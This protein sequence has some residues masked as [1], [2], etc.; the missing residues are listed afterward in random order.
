MKLKHYYTIGKY[1]GYFIL[2]DIPGELWKDFVNRVHKEYNRRG[3]ERHR[4]R[5]HSTTIKDGV[6]IGGFIN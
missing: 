4:N 2:K 5:I 3:I 1:S 6:E